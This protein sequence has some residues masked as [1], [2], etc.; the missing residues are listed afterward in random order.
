MSNSNTL[1]LPIGLIKK[2]M[3]QNG[4]PD[5]IISENV[6]RDFGKSLRVFVHYLT[7]M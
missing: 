3:K 1:D 6:A 7:T 5:M 4:D 2:F